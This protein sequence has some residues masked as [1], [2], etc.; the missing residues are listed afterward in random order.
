MAAPFSKDLR[1]KIVYAYNNGTGTIATVAEL[2]GVS[3]RSVAKFLA[4]A[5]DQR[6]LTPKKSTG[7]PPLLTAKNLATIKNW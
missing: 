1:G 5:R 6:D 2:F 7:R 4:I 3:V